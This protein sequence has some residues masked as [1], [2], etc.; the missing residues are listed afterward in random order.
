MKDPA[1]RWFWIEMLNAATFRPAHFYPKNSVYKQTKHNNYRETAGSFGFVQ[2]LKKNAFIIKHVSR[3]AYTFYRVGTVICVPVVRSGSFS[4][5]GRAVTR[6]AEFTFTPRDPVRAIT[7]TR[8]CSNDVWISAST[9][10][11]PLDAKNISYPRRSPPSSRA[12]ARALYRSEGSDRNSNQI[13]WPRRRPTRFA[14]F[15][16]TPHGVSPQR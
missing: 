13:P 10:P 3:F 1:P 11:F 8:M 15:K 9:H 6:N 2:N 4:P 7:A 16:Y 5:R 14:I 12:R